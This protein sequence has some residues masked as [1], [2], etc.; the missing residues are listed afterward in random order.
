MN[1]LVDIGNTRVKYVLESNGKLSSTKYSHT[2]EFITRLSQMA[3][4]QSLVLVS[5]SNQSFA[6]QC[7]QWADANQVRFVQVETQ[8]SAFGVTNSYT[9]PTQMGT[10]RWVAILAADYLYPNQT[11]LIVDSGTATTIDLVSANK[12]HLGGW[13]IP[14][15]DMMMS[16]LYQNTAKVKGRIGTVTELDF[17]QNTSDNVNL[18]CWAA[19]MGAIELAKMLIA[20]ANLNL[21]QVIFTGGNGAELQKLSAEQNILEPQLIF[22]GLKRFLI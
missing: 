13:I 4:P 10:D 15:V 20:K 8:A 21:E 12:Q 5:V 1:L 7:Q 18:G 17:G 2:D 22:Y 19:T 6:D 3:I 14:G 16:A 9:Y 11:V